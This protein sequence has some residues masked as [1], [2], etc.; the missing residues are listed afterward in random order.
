[1]KSATARQ[2]FSEVHGFFP[3]SADE[4]PAWVELLG[5]F[6]KEARGFGFGRRQ[7]WGEVTA[8]L[9]PNTTPLPPS[10]KKKKGKEKKDPL[11]VGGGR[12]RGG[13]RA[14]PNPKLVSDLE[15]CY[16][17]PKNKL[18]VGRRG[19]YL[20]RKPKNLKLPIIF[21]FYFDFGFSHLFRHVLF[22]F[23]HVFFLFSLFFFVLNIFFEIFLPASFFEIKVFSFCLLFLFFFF[24]MRS[25]RLL[26][27]R[28][29]HFRS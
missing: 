3:R 12:R 20:P 29:Q 22:M 24:S 23:R 1:M 9:L 25:P 15:R 17:L 27:A 4:A 19:Y 6:W 10:P 11:R 13:E 21:Q 26:C 5:S 8:L 28:C 2:Q 16:N 7:G 14:N 18:F